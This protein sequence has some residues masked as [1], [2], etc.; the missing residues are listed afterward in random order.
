ML[1]SHSKKFI[2]VHLYKTA[3]T[4]IRAVLAKYNIKSIYMWRPVRL[5]SR[6]IPFLI[7]NPYPR[8]AIAADIQN[9]FSKEIFE[10]YFKFGFVRNPWAW[11]ASIYHYIL[12]K[13]NHHQRKEI[14]ELRD[15][16]EYLKWLD[17][18]NTIALQKYFFYDKNDNKLVDFIGKVENLQSDFNIISNTIGI[19]NIEL[20]HLNKSEKNHYRDYYN[21]KS[22]ALIYKIYKKDID[23][24]KYEF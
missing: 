23:L 10:N 5:L 19:P 7:K 1:V 24:F 12:R 15:F 22:K 11:Q 16:T 20:P 6:K 3:G 14:S 13:K 9:R 8:H 4:S 18:R 17:K 2:Y 21:T